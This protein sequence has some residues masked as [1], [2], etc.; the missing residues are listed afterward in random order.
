MDVSIM[1]GKNVKNPVTLA[2]IIIKNSNHALLSGNG[3]L[4]FAK[5][6]DVRLGLTL[7]LLQTFKLKCFGRNVIRSLYSNYSEREY[8]EP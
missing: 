4:E 5:E 2:R 8:M 6:E 3:A 1:D 7:I